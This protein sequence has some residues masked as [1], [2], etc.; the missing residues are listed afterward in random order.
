MCLVVCLSVCVCICIC[1]CWNWWSEFTALKICRRSSLLSTAL[2][3]FPLLVFF[4]LLLFD[5]L[6]FSISV[7]VSLVLGVTDSYSFLSLFSLLHPSSSHV[8][9]IFFTF[10]PTHYCAF[11]FSYSPPPHHIIFLS[12]ILPSSLLSLSSSSLFIFSPPPPHPSPPLHLLVAGGAED[13]GSGCVA[14]LS[15]KFIG[16][17]SSRRFLSQERPAP[18]GEPWWI[19]QLNL[20]QSRSSPP[21]L[22]RWILA[23]MI[24]F[25]LINSVNQP[26]AAKHQRR[27]TSW[28]RNG[29]QRAIL[30]A[31]VQRE[32]I[33]L[34]KIAPRLTLPLT[35][36]CVPYLY[37]VRERRW[38]CRS[39]T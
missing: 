36:I 19:T 14:H 34:R 23:L 39:I 9:L 26:C 2:Y 18:H 7:S 1:L 28:W 8:L 21:L 32:R 16:D 15:T 31:G 38:Y 35:S 25:F 24:I 4:Q 3:T 5:F 10:P 30:G 37:I 22:S 29:R 27:N 11:Y 13:T 20:T 6:Y 12:L 17:R 33:V